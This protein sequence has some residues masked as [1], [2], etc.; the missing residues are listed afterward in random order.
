MAHLR[1]LTPFFMLS[2][3]AEVPVAKVAVIMKVKI[4]LIFVT[5]SNAYLLIMNEVIAVPGSV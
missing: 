3:R 2:D 4:A 5:K 1:A